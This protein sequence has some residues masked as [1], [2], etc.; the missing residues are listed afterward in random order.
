MKSKCERG[1]L[2]N[3]SSAGDLPVVE[4]GVNLYWKRNRD[5]HVSIS[6]DVFL[7]A[8]FTVCTARSAN[9]LGWVVGSTSNVSESITLNKG[10]ELSTGEGRAV[11]RHQHLWET[12]T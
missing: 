11:V 9:P 8:F 5:K 10:L 6:P 4:W 7:K 2:P 1:F 3:N 12:M